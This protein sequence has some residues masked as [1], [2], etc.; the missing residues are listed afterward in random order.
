M[1][2]QLL[3][4]RHQVGTFC[5][6]RGSR[7]A[8]L[9]GSSLTAGSGLAFGQSRVLPVAPVAKLA[10]LILGRLVSGLGE[11]LFLTGLMSWYIAPYAARGIG[12]PAG[13]AVQAAYGFAGVGVAAGAG[14]TAGLGHRAAAPACLHL[15][16][17]QSCPV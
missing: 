9:L 2:A 17:P 11:S 3:V 15:R 10:L 1:D 13:L 8:V 7:V 4:T 16:L 5:D 12:A 14:T 6:R